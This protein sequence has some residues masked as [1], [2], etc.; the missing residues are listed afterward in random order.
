MVLVVDSE[1]A[2]ADELTES[3]ARSGYAAIAAYDE[4]T[5]LETALFMPPDLAVIDVRLSGS[6]G[7]KLAAAIQEKLPDCKIVMFEGHDSSS[8]LVASVNAAH[9]ELRKV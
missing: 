5:A 9:V 2:I 8:A 3:L 7:L 6:S 4:E 1:P